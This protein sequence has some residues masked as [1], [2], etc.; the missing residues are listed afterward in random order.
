MCIIPT[1]SSY[2]PAQ[3][4]TN[5]LRLH[6]SFPLLNIHPSSLTFLQS[7]SIP[8]NL[9]RKWVQWCPY[10]QKFTLLDICRKYRYLQLLRTYIDFSPNSAIMTPTLCN[11]YAFPFVSRGSNNKYPAF[12]FHHSSSQVPRTLTT[13]PAALA[14]LNTQATGLAQLV[15]ANSLNVSTRQTNLHAIRTCMPFCAHT[16]SYYTRRSHT[17]SLTTPAT[18]QNKFRTL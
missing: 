10:R 3:M 2:P 16:I 15:T 7:M 17:L 11:C 6:H 8:G 9:P 1:N 13:L 5:L 14:H 18:K 12:Q 4:Y